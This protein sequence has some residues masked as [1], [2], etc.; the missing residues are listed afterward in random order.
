MALGDPAVAPAAEALEAGSERRDR[1]N[2]SFC[3]VGRGGRII[4][5]M[6]LLLPPVALAS[7]LIIPAV[8]DASPFAVPINNGIQ[9]WDAEPP[10]TT[11]APSMDETAPTD[12]A[13]PTDDTAA[14]TDTG[15]VPTGDEAAV[16]E[17]VTEEEGE[18]SEEEEELEDELASKPKKKG[19]FNA[20]AIGIQGGIHLVP[21]YFLNQAL[22]SYGNALC[23]NKVG[24]WG[25]ENGLTKVDGCN[26]FINGG[27]T[28]RI[29]RA[30]DINTAIGY[31]HVKTPDS[32]WIDNDEWDR[33]NCTTDEG[34]MS[35]CNLGAADYTEIDLRMVSIEINFVGRGTLYRNA[36]VEIQMGGGGG[37]G[38]GILVGEGVRRT[39]L[40]DDPNGYENYMN[41][42]LGPSTCT[43]LDDLADFR[44]CTPRYYDDPDVDQDGDGMVADVPREMVDMG[45]PLPNGDS[46]TTN[47][48]FARCTRD[49]CDGGD[50][51]TFGLT[52]TSGTWPVYPLVNI[53][54]SFRIII[55]DT[56]GIEIAGGFKTGFFFG[57]GIQYYFGGGG[58]N[59]T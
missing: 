34:G 42:P 51:S 40:G 44:K 8:A 10:A 45:A 55:K 37:V 22:A 33:D 49:K 27:Y 25:H 7:T 17:A 46:T 53:L 18:A 48:T 43:T 52:E 39:P 54:G 21:S 12:T 5:I 9:L 30:F 41:D 36:D 57:G 26:F 13:A 50:L 56:F 6:R 3:G 35:T 47:S 14:P 20:N 32:M 31:M 28:R 24:N 38:A 23:R 11:A 59:K 1:A 58:H 29:S 16:D 19:D 2:K 4:G 15:E